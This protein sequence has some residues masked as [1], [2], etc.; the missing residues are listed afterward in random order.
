MRKSMLTYYNHLFL[1]VKVTA[2]PR[3]VTPPLDPTTS[4]PPPLGKW[5]IYNDVITNDVKLGICDRYLIFSAS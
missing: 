2:A 3:K 4:W 1:Y 5:L